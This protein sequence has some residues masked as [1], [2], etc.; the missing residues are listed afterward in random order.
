MLF[1]F[2]KKLHLFVQIS[3]LQNAG[4]FSSSVDGI[5]LNIRIKLF[6][7]HN[8]YNIIYKLNSLHIK[9]LLNILNLFNTF[10]IYLVDVVYS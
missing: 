2:F 6:N 4:M 5:F 8:N 10:H 3:K 7:N 9:Y 1:L